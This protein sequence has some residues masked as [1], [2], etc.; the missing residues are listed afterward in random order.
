MKTRE[1]IPRSAANQF[2]LECDRSPIPPS[3][4]PDIGTRTS[5]M[6]KSGGTEGEAGAEAGD[7]VLDLT[8][9]RRALALITCSISVPRVFRS[10]SS[11]RG[12]FSD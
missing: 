11:V 8:R 2:D 7:W 4:F 1:G 12:L 9:A 3:H 5:P 10:E 6:G